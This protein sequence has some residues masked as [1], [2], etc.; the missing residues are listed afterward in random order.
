MATTKNTFSFTDN[1]IGIIKSAL[2]TR[3]MHI[4]D[5]IEILSANK[6]SEFK[7]IIDKYDIERREIE[8]LISDIILH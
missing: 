6:T 2:R 5:M 8:V 4:N 1:Q 3:I 7:F